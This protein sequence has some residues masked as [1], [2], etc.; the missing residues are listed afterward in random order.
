M[1]SAGPYPAAAESLEESALSAIGQA[2]IA[3]LHKRVGTAI[4]P[5]HAYIID[6][7]PANFLYAGAIH[8]ALPHARIIHCRRNPIDTCLSCYSKLFTREQ[9]FTYNQTELGAFHRHY[10][11]L[12]AH[13]RRILPATNFLEIAYETMVDDKEAQTRRLLNFL[14]LPWSDACLD[15]HRTIRPVRT[16][17]VNQVRQP[18][19][20]TSVDR[21]KPY[22]PY[23]RDLL[24]AL[25]TTEPGAPE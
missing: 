8:A 16:A 1:E 12:M 25:A 14:G 2:Y 5:E 22:A 23:L 21:W 24:A 6:K 18:I 4:M 9:L 17:S 15:F 7:M 11:S 19:Y 3:A 20:K 13:W 10:Q